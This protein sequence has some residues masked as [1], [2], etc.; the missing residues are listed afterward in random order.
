MTTPP[1]RGT[2]IEHVSTRTRIEKLSVKPGADV[3]LLGIEHD[4]KFV[5]EL[6]QAGAAIR[7][8]GRTA[9]DMIFALFQHREDLRRLRLPLARRPARPAR[10]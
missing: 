10:P 4:E 9:A 5:G 6:R 2:R 7:T 3:L 8:S 1:R